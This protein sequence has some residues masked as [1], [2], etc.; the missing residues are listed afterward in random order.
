M[1]TPIRNAFLVVAAVAALSHLPL[2]A[3]SSLVVAGTLHVD[4]RATN[5]SAGAATWINAGA[6]GNFTRNGSPG[7]TNDVAG[8]GIAGVYF[9]GT[10]D[11]Y[12]GPVSVPDLEGASDRSVEVWALNPSIAD[13]ETLV[14]W[15]HRGGSPDGSNL[16]I[17]Y[18]SNVGAAGYGAVGHWSGSYDVGWPDAAGVPVANEWHHIVYT[19]DGNRTIN[20]YVDGAL[21]VRKVLP[22]VLKTFG[23][24]S[25]NIGTQRDSASALTSGLRFTGYINTVRV[26]G[27]CLSATDVAANYAY[28]PAFVPPTGPVAITS[29]PQNQS[30]G[31]GG[32]PTFRV[33]AT[34][35][36]PIA[37][38]WYRDGSPL[39]LA[40]N[41][42]VTV[43]PVTLAD[44]GAQLHCVAANNSG[45]TAYSATSSVATLTILTVGSALTH[46]YNFAS[47][48][49][50]VV[51]TAHGA[52]VGA[53]ISG[54][55]AVFS[56]SSRE[57]TLS[58]ESN[59]STG[60]ASPMA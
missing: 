44:N 30:V 11:F 23:G 56:G 34:G 35:Q 5:G 38:Q 25:I 28:G 18:G 26:H 46:R 60:N 15:S 31:E 9:N 20:V 54:G 53:T 2:R 16:S 52:L 45:G 55:Q 29:Q 6:I 49:N 51:G 58:R 36:Q 41:R 33:S 10:T 47:N 42:S 59:S 50:D 17:N 12:Q 3:Q 7:L 39:A 40:T 8:T 4:L 24:F 37:Y 32:T 19:Y 48:A 13:E 14:S 27:G 1:N 57:R 22:D 21:R 43:G